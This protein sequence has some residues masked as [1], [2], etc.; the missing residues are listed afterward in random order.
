MSR[1]LPILVLALL[2]LVAGGTA[3]GAN[4]LIAKYAAAPGPVSATA[5]IASSRPSSGA[6]SFTRA[7]TEEQ[8]LN[9]IMSRN[10]FDVAMIDLWATRTPTLTGPGEVRSDLRAKLLAVAVADPIEYSSALIAE[11]A[12]PDLPSTY[13]TGDMIHDREVVDIGF[14]RVGLKKP[15]G[16]I[17]YLMLEGGELT[18]ALEPE[19]DAPAV[20]GVEQSGDNKF[21]VS[22]DMFEKNINDLEGIS[23]MGRALLHRGPDGEFDGYRLSAIRR[24]TLADQLGIKNGDIIHSVNGSPLN[25]VQSAMNA[26]NTMRSESSFCFEISRRGSPTELCYEVR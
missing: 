15:D 6:S 21:V 7:L 22:K 1:T 10:I 25:S 23:K 18:A 12:S 9:G 26:Y 4:Q 11:E 17:E 5:P 2:T 20:E 3:F 24:N 13:Y 8:Y 19:G 16:T 14:D